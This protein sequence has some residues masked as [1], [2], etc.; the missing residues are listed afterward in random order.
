MTLQE[1]RK[2]LDNVIL[3]LRSKMKGSECY[4]QI[5]LAWEEI[6]RTLDTHAIIT[7]E[8]DTLLKRYKIQV[9]T[10]RHL[11]DMDTLTDDDRDLLD[12]LSLPHQY[13]KRGQE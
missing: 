10:I 1:A 6:K 13:D 2:M 7:D 5:A 4:S 3:S 9:E 11:I 12:A 8:R